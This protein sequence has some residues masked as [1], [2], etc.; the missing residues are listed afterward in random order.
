M[1][2]YGELYELDVD[3]RVNP[4]LGYRQEWTGL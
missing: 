4:N 2:T 1:Q 3:E